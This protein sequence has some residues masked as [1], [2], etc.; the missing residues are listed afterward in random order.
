VKNEEKITR[1]FCPTSESMAELRKRMNVNKSSYFA[2]SGACDPLVR[3]DSALLPFFKSENK[4]LIPYLGHY[5]I[6]VSLRAWYSVLQH[7]EQ[8]HGL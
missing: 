8:N 1:E 7:L 6:K 5:N 3:P 4:I 2:V